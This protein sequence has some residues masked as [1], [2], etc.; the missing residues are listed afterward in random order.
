MPEKLSCNPPVYLS[1][2]HEMDIF[3]IFKKERKINF[4]LSLNEND[5]KFAFDYDKFLHLKMWYNK[6]KMAN[7]RIKM[8]LSKKVKT[9]KDHADL[10]EGQN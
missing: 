5:L 3:W 4:S 10:V 8:L 7:S 2:L 9:N 1:T 6:G